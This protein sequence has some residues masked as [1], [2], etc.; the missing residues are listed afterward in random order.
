MQARLVG[1]AGAAA[2]AQREKLAREALE[3]ALG[4]K[5]APDSAGRQPSLDSPEV[6][7]AIQ[8]KA[9]QLLE[10]LFGKKKP[11]APPPESAARAPADTTR[12]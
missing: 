11:A 8:K 1:H 10:G 4:K 7:E 2:D 12:R 3:G 5:F 6:K 9:N